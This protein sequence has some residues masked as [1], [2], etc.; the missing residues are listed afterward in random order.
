MTID[1]MVRSLVVQSDKVNS[2][3]TA[4]FQPEHYKFYLDLAVNQFI[5]NAYTG[6]NIHRAAFETSEESITALSMLVTIPTTNFVMS[7]S[8][9]STQTAVNIVPPDFWFFVRLS[10]VGTGCKSRFVYV[11]HDDIEALL[12]DPFNKPKAG[13]VLYTVVGRDLIFYKESSTQL[14]ALSY[15]YIRKPAN[16]LGA[17]P[18]NVEYT[19]I[20]SVF[21]PK[22][23]LLALSMMLEGTEN[24]RYNSLQNQLNKL[25]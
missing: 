6:N 19:D 24:P 15:V 10:A 5:I 22:I 20:H 21:H 3:S 13:K 1:E 12:V 25:D 11:Q 16:M 7:T 4:D 18:T 2:L 8:T 14:G 23:V 9:S 17:S